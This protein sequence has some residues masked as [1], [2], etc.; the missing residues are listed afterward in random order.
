MIRALAIAMIALV[1]TAQTAL[2]Q[3]YSLQAGDRIQVIVLEDP[4]LNQQV[5]VRPDGRISLPLAGSIEAAGRTPEALQDV[6]RDRLARDFVTPPTV[7]VSLLS[8]S[9]GAPEEAEPGAFASVYILG[10]VRAPGAYQLATPVSLLQA[11]A[12]SGGVDVFA[13]RNRIQVRRRAE[14]GE[15]LMLFDYESIE[16]GAVPAQSIE[17]MDGDVVIVPERGLFD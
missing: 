4:S 13:A 3:T 1:M 17:L 10:E 14:D 9:E 16:D 11:L 8:V 5:L 6:I 15:T 12:V 2:A 7:T